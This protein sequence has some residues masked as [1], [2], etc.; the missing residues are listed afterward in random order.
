MKTL[1]IWL[2]Q[3]YRMF[4]SPLFPPSCRYTPTCSQYGMQAIER[5]GPLRGSW[6]TIL[7]ILRCHPFHPGGY[8]PVPSLDNPGKKDSHL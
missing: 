6:M 1:L 4:V 7:R 2:I 5:F 8:D 3:G